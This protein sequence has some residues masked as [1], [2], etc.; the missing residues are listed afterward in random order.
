MFTV[1]TPVV[2]QRE[3]RLVVEGIH[4]WLASLTQGQDGAKCFGLVT[5]RTGL[6]QHETLLAVGDVCKR[7]GMRV[8]HGAG[9]EGNA[10]P[11]IVGDLIAQL[12]RDPPRGEGGESVFSEEV[13]LELLKVSGAISQAAP[14]GLPSLSPELDRLR[15]VDAVARAFLELALR[16][17][18]LLVLESFDLADAFSRE[19]VRQLAR[20]LCL[21]RGSENIPRILIVVTLPQSTDLV[22]V[23]D[24]FQD[25]VEAMTAF[26]IE[27]RGYSR[28]DVDEISRSIL[29]QTLPVSVRE[30]VRRST[31]DS[32]CFIRWLLRHWKATNEHVGVDGKKALRWS[33][34]QLVRK[35]FETLSDEQ[36]QLV[37]AL[38]VLGRSFPEKVVLQTI[39][40]ASE[41]SSEDDRETVDWRCLLIE[42]CEAGWA[43]YWPGSQG[44]SY[45]FSIADGDVHEVVFEDIP[46]TERQETHARAVA[47]ISSIAQDDARWLPHIFQQCLLGNRELSVETDAAEA[48]TYLQ[49][50]G[51]SEEAIQFLEEAIGGRSA[52]G[53]RTGPSWRL[54]YAQLLEDTQRISEAIQVYSELRDA[55]LES[56]EKARYSHLIGEL[57]AQHEEWEPALREF[58]IGLSYVQPGDSSVERLKLLASLA[59]VHLEAERL[60]DCRHLVDKCVQFVEAQGLSSDDEYLEVCRLVQEVEVQ[61][62]GPGKSFDHELSRL[63]RRRLRSDLLGCF[64]SLL[65]IAHLQKLRGDWDGVE[66]SLQEALQTARESGSRSLVAQA[67]RAF[68][69]LCRERKNYSAALTHFKQAKSIYEDLGDRVSVRQLDHLILLLELQSG[70]FEDAGESACR[71]AARWGRRAGG[72]EEPDSNA[73]P[74]PSAGELERLQR[75]LQKKAV[76][77]GEHL[78][79]AELLEDAGQLKAAEEHYRRVLQVSHKE[80]A[81][82]VNNVRPRAFL[83]LGRIEALRG[84]F[85][86][87]LNLL[88]Q[89]LCGQGSQPDR[90]ALSASYCEIAW[91]CLEKADL[92]RAYRYYVRALQLA[93]DY[94]SVDGFTNA[95]VGLAHFFAA[96]CSAES[97]QNLI[98]GALLLVSTAGPS[99][100][101]IRLRWLLGRLAVENG[102]A[103]TAEVELNVASRQAEELGLAVESCHILRERGW[104]RYR[105]CDYSGAMEIARSGIEMA[106]EMG[107]EPLLDDLLHLVGVIDSAV[108]N[109]RKNFLRALEALEQALAGAELR[110]RP[111]RRWDVLQAMAVVYSERSKQDIA[112]ECLKRASEIE[113]LV[114]SVL[115][116]ELSGL[117][118]S[119]RVDVRT[120]TKLQPQP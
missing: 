82:V 92:V 63:E 64:C 18:L 59:Q 36:R 119:S 77:P 50:I 7:L 115:P 54:R 57:H 111:R 71:V 85:E 3:L 69:C 19:V 14:V 12:L 26:C 41:A 42:L 116:L 55:A 9:F 24:D 51:F 16:Q 46:F 38:A 84:R 114:F 88:R 102:D 20:M 13:A 90:E 43:R 5:G 78:A 105:A 34:P 113:A 104:Q 74:R 120:V 106:R 8:L 76:P 83:A 108:R 30:Q 87:A 56:E 72:G 70:R 103:K 60:D 4:Q 98:R 101:Q 66:Q 117:C 62:A 6:G 29:G 22:S 21:R 86:Q 32:V 96:S 49:R 109:V 97:S 94:D 44:E 28:D 93:L 118:W 91:I 33:L 79:L 81:A 15:L 68:G 2:P 75:K 23:L 48:L 112:Q 40:V 10:S 45:D 100:A 17:P 25:D 107:L 35:R 99:R 47:A 67:R 31:G 61:R 39:G 52:S 27:A 37:Q 11:G 58:G 110:G 89:S 73:R 80:R 95:I 65:R 1:N 53:L